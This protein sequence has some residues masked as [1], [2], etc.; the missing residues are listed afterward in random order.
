MDEQKKEHR[1]NNTV[2]IE[3]P[4]KFEV[5]HRF[6]A[7][8]HDDKGNNGEEKRRRPQAVVTAVLCCILRQ[9][10]L[11]LDPKEDLACILPELPRDEG[12]QLFH[13]HLIA[14]GE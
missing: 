9:C 4:I 13:L 8:Q 7:H 6:R 10:G 14:L 5:N 11:E 12:G 1:C 3:P 2:K